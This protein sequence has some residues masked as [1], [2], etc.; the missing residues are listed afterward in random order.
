MAPVTGEEA[1]RQAELARL[2]AEGDLEKVRALFEAFFASVPHDRH[3]KNDLANYEGYW[4]ALVYSHFAAA[5][6]DVRVEEA[7]AR[8]R[9]DMAVLGPGC[10]HLYEFKVVDRRQEGRAL[11]QIRER[12]Y[13]DKYRHL[14]VPADGV[15]PEG[16]QH[17]RVRVRDRL[18]PD[19]CPFGQR[20]RLRARPPLTV[21]AA[22]AE[23]EPASVRVRGLSWNGPCEVSSS[24]RSEDCAFPCL[25]RQGRR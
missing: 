12:G 5:G 11:A 25:Q 22:G 9:L 10:V 16:A 7:T 13:A 15:R 23:P 14:G 6:L 21:S 19:E 20:N 4:A 24:T 3:R 1:T 17:R 8:G 2:T 18:K